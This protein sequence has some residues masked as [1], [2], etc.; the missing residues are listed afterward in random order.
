MRRTAIVFILATM[1]RSTFAQV[2]VRFDSKADFAFLHPELIA[3]DGNFDKWRKNHVFGKWREM[4]PTVT[5][6]QVVIIQEDKDKGIQ[7]AAMFAAEILTLGDGPIVNRTLTFSS[8]EVAARYQAAVLAMP[9]T[10]AKQSTRGRPK[11]DFDASTPLTW[12]LSAI[13]IPPP[14]EVTPLD[15]TSGDDDAL[16]SDDLHD[17]SD[18]GV[19]KDAES[20]IRNNKGDPFASAEALCHLVRKTIRYSSYDDADYY[21]DSDA[22]VRARKEGECD[23]KAVLLTTYLRAVGIPARMKFLR[24]TRDGAEE[25]HACVEFIVCGVAYHLDPTRDQVCRPETYRKDPVDNTLPKDVK[26]VD[27]DWPADARSHTAI[28]GLKDPD[29]DGRLN[30]WGDF[31]YSPNKWGDPNRKGYNID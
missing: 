10:A 21:T 4:Q 29:Y 20:A 8:E 15:C 22:L 19:V 1:A 11:V 26:V 18:P 27:V 13:A 30:P 2:E 7:E 17:P 9:D 5:G 28:D 6:K 3:K 23:E 24:W 31:C 12:D 16:S 14:Q 25:Q